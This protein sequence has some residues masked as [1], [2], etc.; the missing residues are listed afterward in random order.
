M[1]LVD[2]RATPAHAQSAC[3]RNGAVRIPVRVALLA[4]AVTQQARSVREQEFGVH[5]TS[6]VRCCTHATALFRIP[7]DE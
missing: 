2:G 1:V 4:L 5:A 6:Q 7:C 3:P